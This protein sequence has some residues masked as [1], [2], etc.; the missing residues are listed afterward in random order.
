MWLIPEMRIIVD[1]GSEEPLTGINS[2]R[3]SRTTRPAP[4]TMLTAACK[5]TKTAGLKM[6]LL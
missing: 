2:S 6:H 3:A 4:T 1:F 5:C